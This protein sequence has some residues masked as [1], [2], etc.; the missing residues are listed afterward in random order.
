[1]TKSQ[2]NPEKRTVSPGK[3]VVASM[4]EAGLTEARY[5]RC[6][7]AVSARKS[8]GPLKLFIASATKPEEGR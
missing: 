4:E 6:P 8:G 5:Q 1:M 7:S 3:D 2:H